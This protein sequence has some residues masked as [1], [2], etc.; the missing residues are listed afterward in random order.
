MPLIINPPGCVTRATG[1]S[2]RWFLSVVPLRGGV[3]SDFVDCGSEGRFGACPS[4]LRRVAAELGHSFL[5]VLLGFVGCYRGGRG[6]PCCHFHAATE[7]D[8][9]ARFS[10][11]GQCRLYQSASEG[12]CPLWT[13][14][15]IAHADAP[16]LRGA[17]HPLVGVRRPFGSSQSP[18]YLHIYVPQWMQGLAWLV[19]EGRGFGLVTVANYWRR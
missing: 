16:W 9:L 15:F 11:C 19:S 1:N 10:P 6:L 4:T 3:R 12:R 18:F 7:R 14:G 8:T 13:N 2:G 5:Q 17:Y